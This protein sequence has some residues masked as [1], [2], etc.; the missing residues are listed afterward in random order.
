MAKKTGVNVNPTDKGWEVKLD[1]AQ[2]ASSTHEKKT[3]AVAAGREKAQGLKTELT[4]RKEDGTI[5]NKN[6]YGNDPN[7]PKDTKP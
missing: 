7:P 2:R 4:I 1:H 5:Q 6:S 3:D